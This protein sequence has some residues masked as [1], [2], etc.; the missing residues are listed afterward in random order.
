MDEYLNSIVRVGT[1]NDVKKPERM[2]R[3]RFPDVNIISGWL[4]VIKSP[5]F[6]PQKD[7][8]Q[9]TEYAEGG[10]GDA[11]FDKHYHEVII[12][13]WFPDIG[14]NV[15]CLFYPTFNGDGFVLGGL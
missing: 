5:P 13:P 9:R 10:S 7:S 4:K 12:E 15:L 3:V 8:L 14:D 11:A 1:V 6:I 2:V